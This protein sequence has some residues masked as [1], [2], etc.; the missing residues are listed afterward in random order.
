MDVNPCLVGCDV[1]KFKYSSL[2]L[3]LIVP[4]LYRCSGISLAAMTVAGLVNFVD[5]SFTVTNWQIYLL[6]I[7]VSISTGWLLQ[8]PTDLFTL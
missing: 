3:S 8:T 6:Y 5:P 1:S 4:F 7:A 2:G